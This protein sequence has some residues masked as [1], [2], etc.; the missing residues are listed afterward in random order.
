MYLKF[1]VY[2]IYIYILNLGFA[3]EVAQSS[4]K[5]CTSCY[6]SAN[7]LLQICSQAVDKLCSH[8]LFPVVVTILDQDVNNLCNKFDDIIIKTCYKVVLTSLI[9]S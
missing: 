8:C 1:M 7:K 6:R 5:K 2:N 3:G 9:Q 4:H